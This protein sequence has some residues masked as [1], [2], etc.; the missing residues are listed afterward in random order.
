[1]LLRVNVSWVD[2]SLLQSSVNSLLYEFFLSLGNSNLELTL[3]S[4]LRNRRLVESY[5]AHSSNLHSYLVTSLLVVLV[6]LNHSTQSVLVHV[7]VNLDVVTLENT[8]AVELHLLASDTRAL[9]N[10]SLSISIAN[11]QSLHL[12][13]SVSL[14]SDSSVEDVRC[15]LDEVSTVS[16]EVSLA[17][18]S[19]DSS[20]IVNLLN[21]NATI[22]SLTVRTLSSDSETT[23]TEQLLCLI[24][25]TFSL[26]ECLLNVSKTSTSHSAKF[27]DI[28]N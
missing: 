22:R 24:E 19:D 23:L 7:V 25:I 1:M 10:S 21:E 13:E 27:L 17:L 9:C 26:C 16:Y 12:V 6:E 3:L 28:F 4:L 2:A 18:E 14:G 20:E 15:Q 5:R 11:L 8:V